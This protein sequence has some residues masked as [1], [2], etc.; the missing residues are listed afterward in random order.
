MDTAKTYRR[1]SPTLEELVPPSIHSLAPRGFN[2]FIPEAQIEEPRAAVWPFQSPPQRERGNWGPSPPSVFNSTNRSAPANPI[3]SA[4]STHNATRT[5]KKYFQLHLGLFE[6]GTISG[7]WEWVAVNK[8]GI[9]ASNA[10]PKS[11]KITARQLAGL[12]TTRWFSALTT[13]KDEVEA[14]PDFAPHLTMAITKFNEWRCGSSATDVGVPDDDKG[15]DTDSWED[16][17]REEDEGVEDYEEEV[18]WNVEEAQALMR[19]AERLFLYVKD[20]VP[21]ILEPE[22]VMFLVYRNYLY[23][24]E[25][26]KIQQRRSEGGM[27]P[28]VARL[29]SLNMNHTLSQHALIRSP[30]HLR[31]Q[32]RYIGHRRGR[33]SQHP[34][35]SLHILSTIEQGGSLRGASRTIYDITS[36]ATYSDL[37]RAL[38]AAWNLKAIDQWN[39]VVE[40]LKQTTPAH[41]LEFVGQW[42]H[43]WGTRHSSYVACERD[44]KGFIAD[45]V[46]PSANGGEVYLGVRFSTPV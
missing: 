25:G 43:G 46:L 36:D 23:M 5:T 40:F 21:C 38:C 19:V 37:V 4:R 34:I 45:W 32:V 7:K 28:V 10:C 1:Q 6:Q 22:I 35:I 17:G 8:L 13:W 11:T 14:D 18:L 26:I 12:I 41:A 29:N 15:S 3:T 44:W 27:D 31:G 2:P 33:D 39:L 9:Q 16:E 42:K 20:G 24:M 30:G